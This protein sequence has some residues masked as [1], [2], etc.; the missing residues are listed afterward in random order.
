M[1]KRHGKKAGPLR[2]ALMATVKPAR[3]C[4]AFGADRGTPGTQDMIRKAEARGIEV[5]RKK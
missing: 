2:N 4:I 1:W 3:Y 5:I